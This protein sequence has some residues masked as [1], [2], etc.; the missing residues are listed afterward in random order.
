[1]TSPGIPSGFWIMT[2]LQ[3]AI[4]ARRRLADRIPAPTARPSTRE[5]PDLHFRGR[6]HQTDV[7]VWGIV[8]GLEPAASAGQP[9]G[10]SS[11]GQHDP[12]AADP[13]D[14]FRESAV[15][16][17]AP[18]LGSRGLEHSPSSL[19]GN[20]RSPGIL[21]AGHL[22]PRCRLSGTSVLFLF[23]CSCPSSRP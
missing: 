12:T 8:T 6:R 19:T 16:V 22:S 9:P 10:S 14:E 21:P 5:S 4:D 7:R 18:I 2:N 17:L 20:S 11:L 23:S 1:M 13:G 3:D 15:R